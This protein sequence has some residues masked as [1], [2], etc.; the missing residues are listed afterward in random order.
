MRAVLLTRESSFQNYCANYL[1]REG[2]LAMAVV[3]S[4]HSFP[5]PLFRQSIP[6]IFRKVKSGVN[7]LLRQGWR[8]RYHLWNKL[9]ME[10]HY[11]GQARYDSAI[12]GPM[13]E[14]LDPSLPVM[15]GNDV[16]DSQI[17]QALQE[18]RPDIIFV[19]GTR[20]IRRPFFDLNIP[21]I[22]MHWGWSPNYRGEGIVSALAI[23]GPEALGVTVHWLGTGIDSGAIIFRTRPQIDATDNFYSIGL[24]LTKLGTNYFRQCYEMLVADSPLPSVTVDSKGRLFDR[25]YMEEHP[26]LVSQ[27]WR[28]LKTMK[29]Q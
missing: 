7:L 8:T 24:K 12:L 19:F 10:Q 28:N 23:E 9:M 26:E 25:R 4:D 17:L 14:S 2:C 3:E 22:N 29:K 6:D 18:M 11:G 20:L 21:M 27:A 16:H 13:I 15:R 1:F 5:V